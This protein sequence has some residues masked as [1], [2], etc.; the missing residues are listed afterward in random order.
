MK[1]SSLEAFSESDQPLSNPAIEEFLETNPN[2]ELELCMKWSHHV[3]RDVKR[4]VNNV[5]PFP[6]LRECLEKFSE[7]ADM[8]VVSATPV[9]ALTKEWR[10]HDI[11][12]YVS[13][14]A[15]QEMGNKK[16]HLE[17]VVSNYED[18]KVLMIGDAPGDMKAAKSNGIL[19]YPI[20]PGDEEASWQRF[21]GEGIDRFFASTYAGAYEEGLIIEFEKYL[22]EKP[23]W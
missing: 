6:N 2:P 12:K 15:G 14:I 16:E 10:E 21:Y 18:G 9:E 5:P 3:N 17:A 23:S 13:L 19:F 11:D 8:M 1:L 22:P 7:A 4:F 20:N